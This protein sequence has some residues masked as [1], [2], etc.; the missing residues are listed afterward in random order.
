MSSFYKLIE[1]LPKYSIFMSLIDKCNKFINLQDWVSVERSLDGLIGELN[2]MLLP[3]NQPIINSWANIK[4]RQSFKEQQ[5]INMQETQTRAFIQ[6]QERE[7]KDASKATKVYVVNPF[8][9]PVY[10]TNGALAGLDEQRDIERNTKRNLARA[11]AKEGQN[12]AEDTIQIGDI[13]IPVEAL[14]TEGKGLKKRRRGRPRGSGLVKVP[15]PPKPPNFVGFGVNE[16]NRKNLEK[17]I[18]TVRRNTKTNYMDMPS[19]HI[20]KNIQGVIKTIIGGGVPKYEDLGKLEEDEK[21]Y[22]HKLVSRSNMSDRLS[23]PAPSKDQQEKDIHN[24]EVMRGQIMSGNDSVELVK[25]FKLL[26]RKLSKQGLLPKA[27]VDDIIDTL[28]DLGY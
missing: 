6:N 14:N 18:L 9:D 12:S 26:T 28:T 8:N 21:E 16:I 4:D 22:L 15:P 11:E 20:S 3:E 17:G 25:K 5:A 7:Q 23:V 2:V 13:Q 1:K 27:D 10:I 24:F 19:K